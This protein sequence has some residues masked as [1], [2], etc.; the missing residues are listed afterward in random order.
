MKNNF[1]ASDK[2]NSCLE[3]ILRLRVTELD[4]QHGLMYVETIQTGTKLILVHQKHTWV[5][6]KFS[7]GGEIAGEVLNNWIVEGETDHDIK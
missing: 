1:R 6:R 5:L 7:V 2:V 3:P 4:R